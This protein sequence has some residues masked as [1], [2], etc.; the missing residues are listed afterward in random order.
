MS[1][2]DSS[3]AS[4]W[5]AVLTWRA[6]DV[7][8]MESARVQVSGDRIKAYGRIVA[9]ATSAHPAFS[10]SYD[11]V[12]D[13]AGATK[14]L[15]LT[16]TLAERERQLSIARDE[17]NM[18]LVQEHSGQTSRSAYDGALDVDVIFS[19]FFNALPIRR[20]GVYKDG[21]SVTVPVVYVR[22][23]DLAVDVETISYAAV[24]G[25]IRLHSP[26]AETVV[27]VDSDGFI[28]DYPGLAE[29]I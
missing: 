22:V 21:G 28:L 1:E 27:T 16:V 12:T 25:G 19:P 2:A 29:R 13:E 14:R 20:T 10:A 15:S 23:P 6:H 11:L 8:R 7:S 3:D 17:E 4:T 9:A 24:D 26:V 5:R 18:W